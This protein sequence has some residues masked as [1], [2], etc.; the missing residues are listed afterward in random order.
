VPQQNANLELLNARIGMNT[1]MENART[2]KEIL[3]WD[4]LVF[5]FQA[6][7]LII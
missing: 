3:E 1:V 7:E 6:K 2:L 5:H 4:I